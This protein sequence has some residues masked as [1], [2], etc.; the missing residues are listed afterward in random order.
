MQVV[1][2]GR[3][4]TGLSNYRKYDGFQ[5]HYQ[6]IP[7]NATIHWWCWCYECDDICVFYHFCI[8]LEVIKSSITWFLP[9]EFAY[10]ATRKHALIKWE[11]TSIEVASCVKLFQKIDNRWSAKRSSFERQNLF[12]NTWKATS[13]MKKKSFEQMHCM[14]CSRFVSISQPIIDAI[15]HY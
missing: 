1:R 5:C 12:G 8:F 10:M 11:K 6:T 2:I 15:N 14:F 9:H 7:S 13:Q 4:T 3:P